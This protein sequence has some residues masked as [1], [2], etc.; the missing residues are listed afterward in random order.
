MPDNSEIGYNKK[1]DAVSF[2][3]RDAVEVF[4][5]ATLKSAI[6]LLSK[7]I[8]P[9]R[10]LTMKKALAMAKQYT[11]QDYKRGEHER[12]MQDL[13]VWIQTMKSAIPTKELSA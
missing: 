13:T 9:T 8:M 6:A 2:V 3:G 11:G 4:R 7:G 5:V 1:G 12:A 10:G